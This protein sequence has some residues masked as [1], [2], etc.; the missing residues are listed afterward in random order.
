MR[1]CLTVG[2]PCYEMWLREMDLTTFFFFWITIFLSSRYMNI[3]G[4]NFAKKIMLVRA[5]PFSVII[6]LFTICQ[7]MLSYLFNK[8]L[9]AKNEL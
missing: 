7:K 6:F 2:I 4:V 3:T 1:R 8:C 9:C 5:N